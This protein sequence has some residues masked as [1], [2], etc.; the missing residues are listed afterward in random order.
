M[1]ITSKTNKHRRYVDLEP[2]RDEKTRRLTGDVMA[3]NDY[4]GYRNHMKLS[5]LLGTTPED[6]ELL[7]T[8]GKPPE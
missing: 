2:I 1:A 6:E 3:T 4:T 5:S 8:L 7:K